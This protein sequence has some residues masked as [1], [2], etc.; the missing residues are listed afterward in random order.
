[1]VSSNLPFMGLG[2]GSGTSCGTWGSSLGF[3]GS[4]CKMG[5]IMVPTF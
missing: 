2:A 3:L 1:M 4:I 5:I